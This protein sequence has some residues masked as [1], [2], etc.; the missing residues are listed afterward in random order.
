ML[1]DWVKLSRYFSAL[2]TKEAISIHFLNYIS[3][4]E[5]SELFYKH[6]LKILLQD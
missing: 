3:T 6:K 4:I 1:S 5:P 2:A